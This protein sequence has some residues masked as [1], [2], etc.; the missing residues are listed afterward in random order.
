VIFAVIGVLMVMAALH[1]NANRVGA[2]TKLEAIARHPMGA[3]CGG[4]RRTDV[5][6]AFSS[7]RPLMRRSVGGQ[8]V[9]RHHHEFAMDRLITDPQSPNRSERINASTPS[10]SRRWRNPPPASSVAR[11]ADGNGIA[12]R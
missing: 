5:F 3:C 12:D 2:W 1:G 9:R 7:V 10:C 4:V 11:R 8:D 6:G